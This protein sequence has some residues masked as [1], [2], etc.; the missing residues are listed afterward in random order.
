MGLAEIGQQ[1][2]NQVN[3]VVQ[4]GIE[5]AREAVASFAQPSVSTEPRD[6]NAMQLVSDRAVMSS[7]NEQTPALTVPG[8]QTE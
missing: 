5:R 8:Q 3:E 6:A 2:A 7:A 1:L 4:A